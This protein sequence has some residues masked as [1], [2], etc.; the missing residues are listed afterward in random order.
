M[1]VN[2]STTK[3][4]PYWYAACFLPRWMHV[5]AAYAAQLTWRPLLINGILLS[6]ERQTHTA[7]ARVTAS[8][9]TTATSLDM[10]VVTCPGRQGIEIEDTVSEKQ[11]E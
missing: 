7:T 2:K 6:A 4:V 1:T 3:L 10:A 11:A 9:S 5:D 8:S